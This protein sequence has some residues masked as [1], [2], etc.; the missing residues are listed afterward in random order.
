MDAGVS[1]ETTQR[2]Y[3][4]YKTARGHGHLAGGHLGPHPGNARRPVC[5]SH[6]RRLSWSRNCGPLCWGRTM[7]Q[8]R[9]HA[10]SAPPASQVGRGHGQVPALPTRRQVVRPVVCA[11][12]SPCGERGLQGQAP[13]P[14]VGPEHLSRAA[15]LPCQSSGEASPGPG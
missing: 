6:P 9:P 11:G 8:V 5:L 2:G 1:P 13:V 7:A 15:Q 12:S 3:Q 4:H 10:H 14:A